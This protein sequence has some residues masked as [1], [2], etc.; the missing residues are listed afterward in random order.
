METP[1]ALTQAVVDDAKPVKQ[2]EL[3]RLFDRCHRRLY[4]LARRMGHG[5]EESRDLV[6]ETF[7]RAARR[8]SAVPGPEGQAEAWL[9]RVLVNLCRDVAR[10][11]R[12]R[13]RWANEVASP[14]VSLES[15]ED[16]SVAR[17]TVKAALGT[18]TPRRR[19]C[20]VLRE[21]EGLTVGEVAETLG[22]RPVT[23]RWHLAAARRQLA[24]WRER[25]AVSRSGEGGSIDG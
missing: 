9:V 4:A 5:Q 15:P 21:L 1:I 12:V 17:A 6:Q 10:R 8:R 16:R 11:R 7:L 14:G 23:V 20:L 19:A 2:V 24:R 25:H 22:L 13:R 18:L 3:G